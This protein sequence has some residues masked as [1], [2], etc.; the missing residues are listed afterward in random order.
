MNDDRGT[1]LSELL[2]RLEGIVEPAPVS[3]APQTAAW[4]ILGTHLSRL[5]DGGEV[6]GLKVPLGD[7]ALSE[8]L[9]DVI[10]AN[11]IGEGVLKLIVT[12]G[13]APRGLLPP[14]PVQPTLLITFSIR[15]SIIYLFF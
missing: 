4:W 2:A 10:E 14:V 12:R 13:P 8:A 7:R 11:A 6:I 5:R 15:N 9:A 3:W 1:T